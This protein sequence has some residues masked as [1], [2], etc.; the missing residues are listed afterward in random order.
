MPVLS[1]SRTCSMQTEARP[2]S[3]FARP[4]NAVVAA[5]KGT[6]RSVRAA[7]RATAEGGKKS[8]PAA[9]STAS[10]DVK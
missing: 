2:R 1:H 5:F 4:A 6:L 7:T 9:A 8:A 10:G 3:V